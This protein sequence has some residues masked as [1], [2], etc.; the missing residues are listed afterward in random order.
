[1]VAGEARARQDQAGVAVGD[2]DPDPGADAPALA[3]PDV[4]VLAGVEV[5]AGVA[6]V[7]ARRQHRVRPSAWRRAGPRREP[8]SCPYGAYAVGTA[9]ATARS[10]KRCSSAAGTLGVDE[11]AVVA[12][13]ALEVAGDLVQLVQAPALAVGDQ[14]L[15]LGQGLLEG[16][17]DPLAQLAPAPP[18]RG[19]RPAPRRGARAA[20]R[21]ARPRSSRSALLRTSSRGFSPAPISSSTSSTACMSSARRSCGSEASTTWTIRSASTVSSSVALNASTSWWGSFSMKP[22][23]SVSR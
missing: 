21:A 11:D 3:G 17:L 13:G 18:R 2:L 9:Q 10:S 14:Q 20:P 23:V 4:G 1:M 7:G 8:T 5:E 6:L 15:D 22:T 16:R 12:V 19:P